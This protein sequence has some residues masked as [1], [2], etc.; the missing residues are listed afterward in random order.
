M[1]P[2]TNESFSPL[3]FY[4]TA[5]Y[6]FMLIVQFD[7]GMYVG[8]SCPQKPHLFRQKSNLELDFCSCLFSSVAGQ[9]NRA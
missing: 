9:R 8:F 5:T 4:R 1:K 2:A 7:D 6:S 3:H